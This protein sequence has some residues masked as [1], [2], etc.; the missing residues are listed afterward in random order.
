MAWNSADE[1]PPN[2]YR[3]LGVRLYE[4]DFGVI[5]SASDQRMT[6]VQ[7]TATGPYSDLS[8]TLLNELAK[9]RA[10]LL[11][12]DKKADYDKK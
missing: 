5:E 4:T 7:Q 2:H 10:C 1:Q 6:Y 8:Q 9:A 11:D 12:S 3:L